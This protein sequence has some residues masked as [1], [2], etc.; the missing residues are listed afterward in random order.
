MT[1]LRQHIGDAPLANEA[2]RTL[3]R[4]ILPENLGGQNILIG[5]AMLSGDRQQTF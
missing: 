4:N 1:W 3:V 2:D 5:I